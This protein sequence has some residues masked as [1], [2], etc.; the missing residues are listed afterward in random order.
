MDAY[1]I[2]KCKYIKDFTGRGAATFGGRWNSKGIY[3][4]YAAATPSLALLENIVHMAAIPS[5]EYCLAKLVIPDNK[6]AEI[7]ESELPS[8][9]A[10]YPS[11]DKLKAIGDKFIKTIFSWH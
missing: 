10:K 3:M 4:I 1:R 9:W 7:K 5:D 8:D 11:P 2:S 6:I